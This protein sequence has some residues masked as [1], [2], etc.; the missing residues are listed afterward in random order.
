MLS[1]KC[2]VVG[3]GGVGKTSLLHSYVSHTFPTEYE[4]TI[5]DNYNTAV[6][7]EDTTYNLGLWDT[8]GQEEYDKMRTV[9]YPHT[10]VFILCFSLVNPH[11]FLNVKQRWFPELQQ[12]CPNA[13]VLLVGTKLDLLTHDETIHSLTKEGLSPVTTDQAWAVVDEL[14]LAGYLEC[15]GLTRKGIDSVFDDAVRLAVGK[16]PVAAVHS[17][18]TRGKAT[19]GVKSPGSSSS[20]GTQNSSKKRRCIIM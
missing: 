12:Y 15:S 7:I 19:K 8:A 16:P 9:S 20:S 17:K 13:P 11:S 5:F 10:Q 1:I 3:D 4:P 6:M 14:A 2:V 18:R